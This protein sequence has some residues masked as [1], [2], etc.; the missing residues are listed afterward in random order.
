MTPRGV[1]TEAVLVAHLRATVGPYV[2]TRTPNPLPLPYIK[3]TRT[4][5]GRDDLVVDAS[6]H[7]VQVWANPAADSPADLPLDVQAALWA[8]EGHTVRGVHLVEVACTNPA[9]LP[10]PDTGAARYV[11]TCTVTAHTI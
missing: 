11:M 10:D 4:G 8:A 2:S 9:S 6:T 1:D 5:G 3:V 7:L